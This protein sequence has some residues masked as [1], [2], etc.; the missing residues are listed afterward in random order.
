MHVQ[1]TP[2]LVCRERGQV[3]A[4]PVFCGQVPGC[5]AFVH[6]VLRCHRVPACPALSLGRTA[7][8]APACQTASA[9]FFM[10]QPGVSKMH[11]GCRHQVVQKTAFLPIFCAILCIAGACTALGAAFVGCLL[12]IFYLNSSSSRVLQNLWTTRFSRCLTKSCIACNAVRPAPFPLSCKVHNPP[13]AAFSVDKCLFVPACSTALS[14]GTGWRA[15]APAPPLPGKKRCPQ[16]QFRQACNAKKPALF[17]TARVCCAS[18]QPGYE[19][20]T[21]RV[22]GSYQAAPWLPGPPVSLLLARW[23]SAPAPPWR[24]PRCMRLPALCCICRSKVFCCAALRAA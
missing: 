11:F 6:R 9:A 21:R 13:A 4:G 3:V 18:W 10:T 23:W 7:L 14:T 2:R 19:A 8:L 16:G 20:V 24:L 5:A 1:R 12:C 22:P 17:P 15:K